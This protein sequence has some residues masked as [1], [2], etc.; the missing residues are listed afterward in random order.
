MPNINFCFL[1][2]SLKCHSMAI[3][4]LKTCE[5][6]NLRIKIVFWEQNI[7]TM[8]M[9]V[10]CHYEEWGQMVTSYVDEI[11]STFKDVL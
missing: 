10:K 5:A 8:M 7:H 2:Q 4:S 11:K 6:I 9:F 1:S 3:K